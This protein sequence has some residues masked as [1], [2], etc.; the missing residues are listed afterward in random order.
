VGSCER[1]NVLSGFTRR[2]VL[3]GSSYATL[4]QSSGGPANLARAP[5]QDLLMPFANVMKIS[6]Q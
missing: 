6:Q 3:R 5:A 2:A 4:R 1:G